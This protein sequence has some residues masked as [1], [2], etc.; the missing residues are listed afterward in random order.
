MNKYQKD[1]DVFLDF[2]FKTHPYYV[3]AS[4]QKEINR[5]ELS[6]K[7]SLCK[8]D[9]G[10]AKIIND[11]VSYLN[12]KHTGVFDPSDKPKKNFGSVLNKGT[13]VSPH[14]SIFDYTILEKESICYMQFNH[15][16]DSRTKKD[17][18][19]PR[20][21]KF[22]DEM[23]KEI[24][25][26]KIKTLVIDVQYNSGGNSR[27]CDELLSY[28]T[29]SLKLFSVYVRKGNTLNK[30]SVH[31]KININRSKI[32][33]GNVVFIQ[34]QDTYSSAAMLIV[35]ARDNKIGTIIGDKSTFPAS[36]FGEVV[37]LQLPNTGLFS[38]CS[39]KYFER[40]DK[41]KINEKTIYPDVLIDTSNKKALQDY[42]IKTYGKT[43]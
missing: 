41:S 43:R 1:L 15:C 23:F 33:E 29:K 40:P 5:E 8:T 16:K 20:F 36:H 11:A 32:Y 2:M 37:E 4:R 9:S 39:R 34:G 19:L 22:L 14:N 7:A 28:L 24:N 38:I 21:D 35:L 31:D 10:F 42:I 30:V 27:L 13:L 26:L 12:D 17:N 18:T 25:S 3:E 6:R